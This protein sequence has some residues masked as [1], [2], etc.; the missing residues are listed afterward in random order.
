MKKASREK[1]TR[2]GAPK[3]LVSTRE[4]RDLRPAVEASADTLSFLRQAAREA[5]K[6][7]A[8]HDDLGLRRQRDGDVPAL[9]DLW[10][11]AWA[12]TMPAIDFEARRDWI[13]NFLE[14]PESGSRLTVVA[15]TGDVPVGF[16]TIE[17]AVAY[18]HQLAVAPASKGKGIA[19]A[20][21]AAAKAAA[22]DGLTLDVNQANTRAVR[23]YEREGFS[24][25]GEGVNAGSGLAT[26]RLGWKPWADA[27]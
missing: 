21:L 12:E 15:V 3:T 20:L 22:P 5:S 2:Q 14:G 18:L 16:V 9:A 25:A 6:L 13:V 27:G 1:Y 24:K 4:T 26:W 19:T 7:A 23:F 11:R 8:T 10:V 17:P